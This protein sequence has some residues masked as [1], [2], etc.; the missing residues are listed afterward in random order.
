MKT[1]QVNLRLDPALKA[2][3]EQAAA[4]DMRSLTSFIEKLIVDHLRHRETAQIAA[5][6]EKVMKATS[7]GTANSAP[8]R[9]RAKG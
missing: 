1:A 2:A 6:I 7:T 9:R 8:V 3:A 5:R 4:D